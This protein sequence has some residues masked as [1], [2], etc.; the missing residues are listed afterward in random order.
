MTACTRAV[1]RTS[2]LP[3]LIT[4]L[5]VAGVLL[6]AVVTLVWDGRAAELLGVLR[7]EDSF[8]ILRLRLPRVILA[9]EVGIA[10]ALA[11]A[12]FQTVLRNDLASPDILGI[13]GGASL[14]GASALLLFGLSGALVSVWAFAGALIVALAIAM[15][16]WRGG[17]SG[18]RFVLIGVG[19]SFVVNSGIGYLLTRAEADDVR[20][21]LVWMVGSIGTPAWSQLGILTI[22]LAA[23]LPLVALAAPRL[24][25]LQLGDDVAGGLG[26]R[27]TSARLAILAL[28]VALAAVATAAAGPVAF[29]AFVSAPIARRLLPGLALLPA[30]M[31]GAIVVLAAEF[32]AQNLGTFEAPVGLVTG[33]IGAPYLLWLLATSDKGVTA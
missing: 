32:V 10:F 28:A 21:A 6:L 4:S 14:A 26:V 30:A 22:A 1:A 20:S 5:L 23:L 18:H 17:M 2:R 16:A 11:G 31:V 12:L 19:I 9:V 8:V 24:R 3:R 15:L 29:V 33:A 25:V 27:V 13:S 7:G